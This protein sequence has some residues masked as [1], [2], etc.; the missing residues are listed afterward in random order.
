MGFVVLKIAS[1]HSVFLKEAIVIVIVS[2]FEIKRNY[3]KSRDHFMLYSPML[4]LEI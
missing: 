4:F 3:V 1:C 2:V